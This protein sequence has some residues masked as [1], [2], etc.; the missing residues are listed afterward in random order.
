V[1]L[2]RDLT[3]LPL[4]EAITAWRRRSARVITM[5]VGQ[6][7]GVLASAY[8]LGWILLELDADERPVR[9]FRKKRSQ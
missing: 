9:A 8:D 5:A 2:H 4:A 3:P 7:D 1:S 6:W